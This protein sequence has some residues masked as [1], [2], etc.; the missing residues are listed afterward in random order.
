M[1]ATTAA[2]LIAA[3]A[4]ASAAS[5]IY[6]AKKAGAA[7]REANAVSQQSNTEALAFERENEE[8]RRLEYDQEQEMLRKA[9]EAEQDRGIEDSARE[10]ARYKADDA[11]RTR[12]ENMARTSWNAKS[13]YRAAGSSAVKELAALAGLTVNEAPPME[14]VS[15]GEV[16]A[17]PTD[18]DL[19]AKVSASRSAM[20]APS[21]PPMKEPN[22]PQ[23]EA[24]GLIPVT[25]S[26]EAY[27]KLAAP[28]APT[29]I[30]RPRVPLNQMIQ[31][32]GRH[33]R[34]A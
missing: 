16:P 9:W 26:A 3:S 8:R 25:M 22:L 15:G 12:D 11:R 4:G 2:I 32:L 27:R 29:P 30:A 10:D 17:Y 19:A 1:V 23:P 20:P 13:P 31:P 33:E 7:S 5:G 6:A 34:S 24:D 14:M 18:T 28:K 21:A